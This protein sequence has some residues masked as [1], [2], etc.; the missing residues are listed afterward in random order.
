MKLLLPLSVLAALFVVVGVSAH[1]QRESHRSH[2][3][4]QHA[5]PAATRIQAGIEV[6]RLGYPVSGSLA[7]SPKYV[8]PVSHGRRTR[9]DR[10]SQ[11]TGAAEMI[12]RG[13]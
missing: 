11:H 7:D 5:A 9:P 6:D 12:S 2:H 8:D 10:R 3:H 4:E 1:I 13:G